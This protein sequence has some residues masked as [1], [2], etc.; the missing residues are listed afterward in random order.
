MTPT[1]RPHSSGVSPRPDACSFLSRT[2][3]EPVAGTAPT[4]T[5]YVIIENGG[6]WPSKI[7][8]A[9]V[10]IGPDGASYDVRPLASRLDPL[11]VTLLFARRPGSRHGVPSPLAVVA[12]ALSPDGGRAAR[13]T[14]ASPSDLEGLNLR[15][16]LA[17]LRAGTVP[18][19]WEP[20][21][22]A[23]YVCTH[24]MRDACCAELGRPVAAAFGDAAGGEAVWEVSHLG[25]HRLAANVLLL[26]DGLHLGRVVPGEAAEVVAEVRAGRIRTDRLRG[27]SAL[28]PSVQAAEIAVRTAAGVDGL[29]AVRLVG[30]QA[31]ALADVNTP[32]DHGPLTVS[33]WRVG[34]QKWTCTVLTV[35]PGGDPVRESCGAEPVAPKPRQL[36]RDVRRL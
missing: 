28:G 8:A 34:A 29:D 17:A 22:E 3:G 35:A 11:G 16:V 23:Y 32:P 31:G 20:V 4:A 13:L 5:G 2:A 15:D 33:T 12:A 36:A 19:G 21:T 27:R 18:E 30:V 9:P 25:G 24:G 1:D 6:P 10:L 7:L 14:V 26:P